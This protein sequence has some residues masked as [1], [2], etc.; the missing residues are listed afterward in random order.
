MAPE[1]ILRIGH[2]FAFDFYTLGALLYEIVIGIPPF[3]SQNED[4]N[5]FSILND[6]LSFPEEV[7][8]SEELKGLLKSLLN[9]NPK[10]RLGCLKGVKEIRFH[11]WVGLYTPKTI[12]ERKLKPPF[13][14][15]LSCLNFDERD[16]GDDEGEFTKKLKQEI[17]VLN[18]SLG[19]K[20]KSSIKLL[21]SRSNFTLK[22]NPLNKGWHL[23]RDVSPYLEKM[24]VMT[25]MSP[26]KSKIVYNSIEMGRDKENERLP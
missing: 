12:L 5:R 16:V 4:V 1:M 9:K 3:Y 24:S 22:H 15:D 11:P 23:N 6:Q 17:R 25:P 10:L 14:P 19:P 26:G 21:H 7:S 18:R 20:A 8:L 2:S 13:I